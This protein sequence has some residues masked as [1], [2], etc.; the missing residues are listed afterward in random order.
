M[1]DPL[2]VSLAI[3]GAVAALVVALFLRTALSSGLVAVL[4][5]I[6]GIILGAGSLLV[7]ERADTADWFVTLSLLALLV[8][9]HVRI[10]LGPFGARGASP[11]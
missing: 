4:L 2:G 10:V 6:S 9:A 5:A 7:Q 3:A 1:D 11:R 8:P